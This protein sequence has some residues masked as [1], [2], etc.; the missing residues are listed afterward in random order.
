MG[1][2]TA[3]LYNV[4]YAYT[5]TVPAGAPSA[6]ST[7]SYAAGT[8]VGVS[9][10]VNVEGY[11][12]S[13]WTTTDTTI[14]DNSFKMPTNNVTLTGSFTQNPKYRVTYTL[15]GTTP[16]GYVLPSEKEYYPSSEV[17]LDT[18][19]EGDVF[20]GYRFLGWTTSDVT[21]SS[22]RDFTMPTGNVNLVGNF[23]EVTY[24]VTYR[25]YDGVLPP[26]AD[27]YLP[28]TKSYKP[29]ATVTVEDVLGEPAGY[30][31]L[32]WY[33]ESTFEMPENDITIY[34]E[35]KVQSGTFEPTITKTV[36][37][38][39]PY[40]RVG[41]VVEFRI[42][43]TNPESFAINNVIVKENTD[44]SVFRAGTGYSVLSDH[45]ANIDTIPAGGSVNL[46][47]A[48]TV[49]ATDTGT[50]TNTAEIKGALASNNYELKDK[51]YIATAPFKI[52]SKI[53][54]CKEVSGNYNE[55]TFQFHITGNTNNYETWITLEDG[56]CET[57][58]VDPSTYKI[59]EIVPQEYSIKSVTGAI[60]SNN[61]DLVVAEGN[62]YE[63]TYTNEFIK[64]GFLH[65]FGRVENR[66]IQ[67][68]N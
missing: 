52:Q 27:N 68:G 46:I 2:E 1:S 65:S 61:S 56:E 53:K 37:S 7:S 33:K 11:T 31:F 44:N 38:T 13:G 5:G 59:N 9:K 41:D 50:I 45:V 16:Q 57:I 42:T 22:D 15:T 14:T 19:K 36:T 30:K 66:I 40:Y 35:W 39:K 10:D 18:L 25:F 62:D 6:P 60:T 63:I 17:T 58:F 32:G 8:S 3:T 34:G 28:T 21:I 64:K 48:Y 43:V 67:G 47:A 26:N 51:E 4:S 20:N 54:V 49:G 24:K 12:F 23:E 55:N 29:G